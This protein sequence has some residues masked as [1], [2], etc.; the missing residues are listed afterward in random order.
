MKCTVQCC[1]VA[2]LFGGNNPSVQMSVQYIQ[3]FVVAV[4]FK[5]TSLE[6]FSVFG[7]V[8]STYLA[9]MGKLGAPAPPRLNH[10]SH[11]V[12]LQ[13]LNNFI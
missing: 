2:S 4:E 10:K 3:Y 13:N 11:K 9:M 7:V 6:F 12:T 1:A 8:F 5:Q